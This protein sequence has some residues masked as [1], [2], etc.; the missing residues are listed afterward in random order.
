MHDDFLNPQFV[1][2]GLTALFGLGGALFYLFRRRLSQPF[3]DSRLAKLY[4]EFHERMCYFE[5]QAQ[6]LHE[7]A[8]DYVAVFNTQDWQGLVSEL[9]V[10][11]KQDAKIRELTKA[12]DFEAAERLLREICHHPKS[13][14]EGLAHD[15]WTSH[16]R[17]SLKRVIHNLEVTT[18]EAHKLSNTSRKRG[19]RPTLVTL[20]DVKKSIL[21]DEGIRRELFK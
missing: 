9:E 13:A 18:E 20:A 21:E 5:R 19:R 12:G 1:F 17:S 14:T 8:E 7:H 16:I 10:L 3:T 6:S 15:A 11:R 2:F 4:G